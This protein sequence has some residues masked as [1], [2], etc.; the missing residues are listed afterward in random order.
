MANC[1][2]TDLDKQDARY[3]SA[4]AAV[5]A[6]T[7]PDAPGS[8]PAPFTIL[9][10]TVTQT[11]RMPPA[12]AKAWQKSFVKEVVGILINRQTCKIEEPGPNDSVVPVMEVY[13][14][15]LDKDGLVDKLKC[16]IV[17]RGDLYDPAD[18]Q[19]PWNPHASFLALKVFLAECARLGIFPHQIDFVLAYLQANMRER[20]FIIFPEAWKQFLP[21]HVHKYIGRPVLLLKALYGYNYSGKFLYQD[22]ADFLMSQGLEQT[23][24]PGL[25]VKFYPDGSKFMF[26]HYS[27]DIMCAGTN[28]KYTQEFMTAIKEKFDVEVK[29]RAD[30]YLQTRIQ[31]DKD[32]NITIDQTRYAKSMVARFLP[33]LANS[34]V[35]PLDLR[36]YAA[37][38]KTNTTLTKADC[39]K[40]KEAVV[41]L[42]EEYGFRYI[43]IVG[44]FNWISY[45]CYEE[46]YA[47]RKLCKYMALP[48][49][50]HFQ[51]ALHLLHHFR[52][53]PPRPLIFY[54]KIEHAPIIK[55][56]KEIP[57]FNEKFD[58]L[59]LVFADSAHADSDEGKS[60]ACD[61]QV[62]QGGLIDHISWTPSPVSMSTAESEN[63]AYSAAIMRIRFTSKAISK[64]LYNADDSAVTVPVL[65]D[66]SAAI[67]MNTSEKPTRKT[68]HVASRFWYGRQAIQ[69]GR[70]AFVK[71][72]GS[73]QQPADVGT[74]ILSD[75]ESQYY[76]Y[77][78]EAPY[79]TT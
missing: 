1:L 71:V 14:C 66:S 25:W 36:K 19:D 64:L 38:L 30:W 55:M 50:P 61:L 32:L 74:K 3:A 12:I 57:Q 26:L 8:D 70:V 27:D 72:D 21:E 46:I 76:R 34:D 73:T 65:V 79:Y 2:A 56:L 52:C 49:R 35:T 75:R 20:V 47:I 59:L 41:E 40:D 29:P 15:K 54:H 6:E 5:M 67:A 60:T 68:R 51:A 31:Q 45:T 16:R 48:G 44:C 69:E 23:G 39:A 13:R 43:K 58:P 9:P 22:Q 28:D 7:E 63:N 18:P 78:F 37:P 24:L 33:N 53:H 62:F 10:R 77:L 42:E 17:F 11:L 4:M